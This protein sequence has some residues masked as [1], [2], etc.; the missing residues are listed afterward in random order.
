MASRRVERFIV[1]MTD[2]EYREA[3]EAYD[4]F[5]PDAEIMAFEEFIEEPEFEEEFEAELE[6]ASQRRDGRASNGLGGRSHYIGSQM[7]D[8][9]VHPDHPAS[10]SSYGH[11]HHHDIERSAYEAYRDESFALEGGAPRAEGGRG[12]PDGG[13]ESG[14]FNSRAVSSAGGS[15][16]PAGRHHHHGGSPPPPYDERYQGGR[17]A[18]QSSFVDASS[19]HYV[20]QQNHHSQSGNSNYDSYGASSG[21]Y[22]ERRNPAGDRHH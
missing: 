9:R 19:R 13:P 12:G 4:H 10:G 18:A 22:G 2:R 7:P 1:R 17:P 3:K 21:G 20:S 8:P 5:H 16:Y 15:A 14:A 11:G 6:E